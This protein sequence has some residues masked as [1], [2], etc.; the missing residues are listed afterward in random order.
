MNALKG[1][2]ALAIIGV[3]G[4]TSTYA[5]SI[6]RAYWDPESCGPNGPNYNRNWCNRVTRV[7][8]TEISTELCYRAMPTWKC[9]QNKVFVGCNN[10]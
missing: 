2:T 8:P 3:I 4:I 9:V 7:C 10:Q 6:I 1:I 5:E